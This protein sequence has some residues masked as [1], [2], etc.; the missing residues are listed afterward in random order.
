MNTTSPA[1]AIPIICARAVAVTW[2]NLCQM[3]SGWLGAWCITIWFLHA[4]LHN[5][6]CTLYTPHSTFPTS[7]STLHTLPHFTLAHFI[8]HIHNSHPTL[9]TTTPPVQ[10]AA[11]RGEI[12]R[13]P[14]TFWQIL[15]QFDTSKLSVC[16]TNGRKWRRGRTLCLLDISTCCFFIIL[17]HDFVWRTLLDANGNCDRRGQIWSVGSSQ[18]WG[19]RPILE[20]IQWFK[21]FL[22]E[23]LNA[24]WIPLFVSIE[25]PFIGTLVIMLCLFQS[26]GIIGGGHLAIDLQDEGYVDL[27]LQEWVEWWRVWWECFAFWLVGIGS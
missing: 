9:Y 23:F 15:T 13:S 16:H 1:H 7:Q 22:W 14:Y 24:S 25:F 27:A 4:T 26:S 2:K 20:K 10:V 6:H 17:F 3:S 11:W 5:P 18:A 8:L 12:P 21:D 19:R